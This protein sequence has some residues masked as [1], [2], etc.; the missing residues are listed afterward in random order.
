LGQRPGDEGD[1]L[2]DRRLVPAVAVLFV[3]GDEFAVRAGAGGTAG[4]GE[5]HQRQ[6]PRHLAGLGEQRC[7]VR[8]NRMASPASSRR[9]RL[10]PDVAV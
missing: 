3:E 9:V 8:V 6:Q 2:L 10:G 7:T 4:V 5:Q 1:A